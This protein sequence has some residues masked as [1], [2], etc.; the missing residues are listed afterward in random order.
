[1]NTVFPETVTRLQYLVRFVIWSGIFL[2]VSAL[3]FPM[4]KA[5]RIPDW[6]PFLI[7]VPLFFMRFPCLDIPRCRDM[8][9]SPWRL[10]LVLVPIVGLF[11]VLSLFVWP[12]RRDDPSLEAAPSL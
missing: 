5:F 6:L 2:V 8:G 7:V 1:M 12:G 3:L 4:V 10:L 9:W 11:I